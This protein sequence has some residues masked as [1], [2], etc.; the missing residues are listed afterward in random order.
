MTFLVVAADN[1]T[2]ALIVNFVV[3]LL[4]QWLQLGPLFDLLV[5]LLV[6]RIACALSLFLFILLDISW[7]CANCRKIIQS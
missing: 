6:Y 7:P 2:I 4:V 5:R 3:I 1:V